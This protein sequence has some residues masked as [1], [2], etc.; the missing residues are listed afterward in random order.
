MSSDMERFSS[1]VF[2]YYTILWNRLRSMCRRVCW[3]SFRLLAAGVLCCPSSQTPLTRQERTVLFTSLMVLFL[4][5]RFRFVVLLFVHLYLSRLTGRSSLQVKG[6]WFWNLLQR[7]IKLRDSIP[8]S[9]PILFPASDSLH[10][11]LSP[12]WEKGWVV[13]TCSLLHSRISIISY[14][15]T[16][17]CHILD[18]CFFHKVPYFEWFPVVILHLFL[19]PTLSRTQAI[20]LC[21]YVMCTLCVHYVYSCDEYTRASVAM[22]LDM[23]HLFLSL[24]Q[25]L[26]SLQR[27]LSDNIFQHAWYNC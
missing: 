6:V 19:I 24:L 5:K 27:L 12:F 23:L 26:W 4:L 1:V 3:N 15:L 16:A 8:S 2:D 22:S 20:S 18:R 11:G 21:D 14:A 17:S 7:L 10:I 9:S 25:V 13:D